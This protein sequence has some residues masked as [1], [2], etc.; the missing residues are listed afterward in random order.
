MTGE[1][2]ETLL[3]TMAEFYPAL[4]RD[5]KYAKDVTPLGM[6]VCILVSLQVRSSDI[7]NMLG[8]SNTQVSNLKQDL[9]ITLFNDNSA[10]LLYKNLVNHYHIFSN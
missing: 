7:A 3:T 2:R 4:Y 8:I 10:R 6:L 5:L 9:N 1:E